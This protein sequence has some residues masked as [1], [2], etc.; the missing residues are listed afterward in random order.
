MSKPQKKNKPI[1]GSFIAVTDRLMQ[2]KEFDL[3]QKLIIAY[4]SSYQRQEMKFF[5]SKQEL[6]ERF[7]CSWKTVKRRMDSLEE[8]GILIRG[9]K[10]KRTIVYRVNADKLETYLT[11]MYSKGNIPDSTVSSRKHTREYDYKNTN[12]NSNKTIFI[13]EETSGVSS[14]KDQKSPKPEDI[15]QWLLNEDL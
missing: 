10:V 8:M 9:G 15:E 12:K 2:C 7:D 6:A 5:M 11:G 14:S 1:N 13:E 3:Y 4:I